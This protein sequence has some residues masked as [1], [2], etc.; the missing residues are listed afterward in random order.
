MTAQDGPQ[1]ARRRKG[2]G[3]P[4]QQPN[5]RWEARY[6]DPLTRKRRGRSFDSER[7]ALAFLASQTVARHSGDVVVGSTR[8]LA[9]WVN[10]PDDGWLALY[11]PAMTTRTREAYASNLA[12]YVLPILGAV[13]LNKL[14]RQHVVKLQN[15]LR[16]R[17]LAPNTVRG[18]HAALSVALSAAVRDGMLARNVAKLVARPSA[19]KRTAR[20]V[21]IVPPSLEELGRVIDALDGTRVQLPFR[22]TVAT[23]LRIGELQGL[24]WDDLRPLADGGWALIV[25]GK[26]NDR[27]REYDD[28]TK[29]EAGDRMVRITRSLADDLAAHRPSGAPGDAYIFPGYQ[30]KV[31]PVSG[32]GLRAALRKAQTTAG[33]RPFRW[34][35]VRHAYPTVL[36]ARGDDWLAISRSMGHSKIAVTTGMYGHVD[37]ATV[38]PLD[39]PRDARNGGTK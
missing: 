34:H 19:P 7:E 2:E 35:D 18:A 38:A 16:A 26:W 12:R 8:K 20:G 17:K 28:A 31:G 24:R 33:V 21:K 10:G 14:T 13:P 39:D 29:T 9:D 5:G 22:V 1:R 23:G 27:A 32:T 4:R 15:D 37:L 36:R 30:R 11:G 6:A 25:D 3:S